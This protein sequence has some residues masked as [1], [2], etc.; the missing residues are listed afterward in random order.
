MKRHFLLAFCLW[1]CT[2]FSVAQVSDTD[3]LMR[4]V[5]ESELF[6][7]DTSIHL[8]KLQ[9]NWPEKVGNANME[10]LQKYLSMFFFGLE[11]GDFVS[12]LNRYVT[13]M[14]TPT[15]SMPERDNAH[16]Y[17]EDLQLKVVWFSRD[18]CLTFYAYKQV[19]NGE[20][21]TLESKRRYFTYDL[22]N[23]KVLTQKDIFNQSR[24]WG[25]YDDDYRILFEELLEQFAQVGENDYIDISKQPTDVALYK[26]NLLIDL[27]ESDT[28]PGHDNFS[29]IPMEYLTSF[30]SKDFKKWMK[31]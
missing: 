18:Q 24:L 10:P 17:Y 21:K 22:V 2:M 30:F 8:M 7:N 28:R 4:T 20:G 1:W 15:D 12:A 13:P 6:V 9:V 14:G 19:R 25:V 5:D 3:N 26:D 16:R 11:A 27:G 23:G 31:H 29:L